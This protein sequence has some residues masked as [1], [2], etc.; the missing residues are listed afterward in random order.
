[1]NIEINNRTEVPNKLIRLAK[2]KIYSL[3]RKFGNVIYARLFINTVAKKAKAYEVTLVL[4][5]EGNDIILK[6]RAESIERLIN[7][8]TK[9]AH[10][11][12]NRHRNLRTIHS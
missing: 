8:L 4:G 7:K 1:M 6:E 11:Y 9:N 12:L 2:W 3:N 10:R 5:V